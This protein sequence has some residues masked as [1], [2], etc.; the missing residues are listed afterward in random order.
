MIKND[1]RTEYSI[2]INGVIRP[3]SHCDQGEYLLEVVE[4]NLCR[5]G[6]LAGGGIPIGLAL[7]ATMEMVVAGDRFHGPGCQ[8]GRESHLLRDYRM[9]KGWRLRR[10]A[11]GNL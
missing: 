10:D 3:W 6:G 7:P 1:D 2:L 8:E 9:G 11:A 4:I 5:G